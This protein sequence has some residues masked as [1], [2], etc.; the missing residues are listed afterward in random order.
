MAVLDYLA[1]VCQTRIIEEVMLYAQKLYPSW[2]HAAG[3]HGYRASWVAPGF[4]LYYDG[5]QGMGVYLQASGEGCSVISALPQ[6]EGWAEFLRDFMEYGFRPSRLDLAF[7]DREGLLDMAEMGRKLVAEECTTRYRTVSPQSTFESGA[8]VR[9]AIYLG[10]MASDSSVCIYDKRLETLARSEPDPGHWVRVEIRYKHKQ[11]E[12]VASWIIGNGGLVG[13]DGLLGAGIE[14]REPSSE[15]NKA[16]WEISDFWQEFR[17]N[18]QRVCRNI[19]K[20]IRTI[21]QHANRFL[22][23]HAP[24]LAML[25]LALCAGSFSGPW[26]EHVIQHGFERMTIK[27]QEAVKTYRDARPS[28]WRPP[29][30]TLEVQT[31]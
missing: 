27:Q 9:D 18:S 1:G 17:R 24:T 25:V 20:E 31:I 2:S 30:Q 29:D 22:K 28:A 16:R 8:L 6:F 15:A 12:S 21:E 4:R 5:G 7:D 23:Q 11:A 14:F 10:T 13:A 3:G 26:L 19:Q